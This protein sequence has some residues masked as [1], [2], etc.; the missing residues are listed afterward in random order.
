[1]LND[2]LAIANQNYICVY[3]TNAPYPRNIFIS[4]WKALKIPERHVASTKPQLAGMPVKTSWLYQQVIV[5]NRF[6]M[7][8]CGISLRLDSSGTNFY[9]NQNLSSIRGWKN[10]A[11]FRDTD[12]SFKIMQSGKLVH[13]S[14]SSLP[15]NQELWVTI[16][17]SSG[18]K[19][20]I[21]SGSFQLAYLFGRNWRV[22]L[23]RQAF[24]V[25]FW[26]TQ[27]SSYRTWSCQYSGR[28]IH[29]GAR[30]ASPFAFDSRKYLCAVMFN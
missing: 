13:A 22:K 6:I 18:A 7:W 15:T 9:S 10:G 25:F 4:L 1:M 24:Y 16:Y 30:C 20:V 8:A 19:G 17:R 3:D 12:I 2:A 23:E 29:D 5:T 21:W 28:C 14:N 11:L 27:L 26:L